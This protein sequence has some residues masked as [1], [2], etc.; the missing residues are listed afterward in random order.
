[1][2]IDR[3]YSGRLMPSR[4]TV[5]VALMGLIQLLVVKNCSFWLWP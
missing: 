3:M 1:M 5:Y 2:I 4:P